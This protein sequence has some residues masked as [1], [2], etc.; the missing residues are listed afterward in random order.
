MIP[1]GSTRRAA[2]ISSME[3][4]IAVKTLTAGTMASCAYA[5][6]KR[7]WVGF[8]FRS[9]QS[10]N[11][12]SGELMATPLSVGEAPR[13]KHNDTIALFTAPGCES[14]SYTARPSRLGNISAQKIRMS[15]GRSTRAPRTP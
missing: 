4:T 8:L 2:P 13:Q 15:V 7:S 12:A 6:T 5:L 10:A 14:S 3:T 11:R 9:G 1:P